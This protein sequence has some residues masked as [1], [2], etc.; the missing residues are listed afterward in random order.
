MEET[1]AVRASHILILNHMSEI[2]VTEEQ[3]Q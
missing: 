2:G 3:N 1:Y